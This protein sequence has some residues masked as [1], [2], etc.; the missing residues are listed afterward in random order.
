M[1]AIAPTLQ[2]FFTERLARQRGASPSTIAS[3]RDTLRLLLTFRRQ[4]RPLRRQ[5]RKQR[6]VPLTSPAQAV[7]REWIAARGGTPDHPL[8]PTRTGRR[9]SRD[10]IERR[11]FTASQT[12][13]YT[14]SGGTG[15]YAGISGQGTATISILAVAARNTTGQCSQ[16]LTPAAWHQ[17]IEGAGPS[18]CDTRQVRLSPCSR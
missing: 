6:A 15:V 18:I 2:A 1:T 9:L 11:L 16:T 7:L 14:I 10:A 5:G 4:P 12:G 17:V 8:F 3:Y 13:K